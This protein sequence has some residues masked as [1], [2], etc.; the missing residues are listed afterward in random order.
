M[1]SI[2]DFLQTLCIL[3]AI[4]ALVTSSTEMDHNNTFSLLHDTPDDIF[5]QIL[6]FIPRNEIKASISKRCKKFLYQRTDPEDWYDQYVIFSDD[7]T[8]NGDRDLMLSWLSSTWNEMDAN[9]TEQIRNWNSNH[10]LSRSLGGYLMSRFINQRGDSLDRL[11]FILDITNS[12]L[13]ALPWLYEETFV[14]LLILACTSND[15]QNIKSYLNKARTLTNT[16]I[17]NIGPQSQLAKGSN[18]ALQHLLCGFIKFDGVYIRPPAE[19]GE[20]CLDK[21]KLFANFLKFWFSSTG[22]KLVYCPGKYPQSN[23]LAAWKYHVPNAGDMY[24]AMYPDIIRSVLM[25]NSRRVASVECPDFHLRELS[26][27][28]YH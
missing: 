26:R 25:F 28:S 18:I 27:I 23:G 19:F 2:Q 21:N 20:E 3:F 24:D 14:R 10:S 17:L 1:N 22:L 8:N 11:S 7:D 4:F 16:M 6:S 13:M 12:D 9:K 15:I 5:G